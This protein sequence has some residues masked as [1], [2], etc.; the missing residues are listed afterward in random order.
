MLEYSAIPKR[1]ANIFG[2]D[3]SP[4]RKFKRQASEPA[5]RAVMN[6]ATI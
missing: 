4:F 1:G 3:G 2:G 5:R 6:I